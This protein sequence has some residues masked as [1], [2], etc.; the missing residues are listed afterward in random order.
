MR[1][2]RRAEMNQEISA[3]FK[4]E[5]ANPAGGCLPLLIQMP[6]LFAFYSMLASANE[7]RHAGWLWIHDLSSP[8]PY[9]IVPIAIMASTF[10]M[11]K[12]TPQGGMDPAQQKVMTIMMP[13][14]LGVI[15]W[16]LSAGLGVY[17]ILG[18]IIGILQQ[19]LLNR[20]Q[21]GREMRELAEKRARHRLKGPA[22]A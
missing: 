14:M 16:T 10:A 8:D 1:D 18:N 4:R 17:W 5:G 21:F 19:V 11:Q 12:M 3:L 2:P 7:L 20:T 6:F 22:K 13:V 15:S 9:Y